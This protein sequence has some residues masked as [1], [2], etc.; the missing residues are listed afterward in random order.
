MLIV[1][2]F[3]K[4]SSKREFQ[5]RSPADVPGP[6]VW[7]SRI[8]NFGQALGTLEENKHLGADEIHDPKEVQKDFGQNFWLI[9]RSLPVP[10]LSTLASSISRSFPK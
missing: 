5:D 8:K 6:F 10:S 1:P 7:T 3:R 4:N 2:L 9:F